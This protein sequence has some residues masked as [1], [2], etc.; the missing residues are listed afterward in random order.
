[1]G[2]TTED[3]VSDDITPR[4]DTALDD[5]GVDPRIVKINKEELVP[6]SILKEYRLG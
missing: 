1:M 2:G 6:K 5:N 4:T 3:D